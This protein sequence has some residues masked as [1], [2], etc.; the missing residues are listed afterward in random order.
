MLL[1]L[2]R[3]VMLLSIVGLLKLAG[4]DL[5]RILSILTRIVIEGAVEVLTR[6][7]WH[8]VVVQLA[9]V[10]QAAWR[11]ARCSIHGPGRFN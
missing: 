3:A 9:V 1:L 2:L 8:I 4:A 5:A 10:R 6:A 11:L 7:D